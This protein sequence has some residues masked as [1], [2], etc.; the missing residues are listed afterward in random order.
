MWW[1][2]EINDYSETY[3]P[4]FFEIKKNLGISGHISM[5][6]E[7]ILG[8]MPLFGD[9]LAMLLS[10]INWLV[11]F[12]DLAWFFPLAVS[13]T[14]IVGALGMSLFLKKIGVKNRIAMLFGILYMLMPLSIAH[15]KAGHLNIYE[16]VGWYPW[17]L[18]FAYK[19]FSERKIATV[20]YASIFST[21][22]LFSH[23]GMTYILMIFL[24]PIF[25]SSYKKFGWKHILFFFL[26]FLGL[27]AIYLLPSLELHQFINR[28]SITGEDVVPIWTV[29]AFMGGFFFPYAKISSLDQ[30]AV[31]Y[32]GLGILLL[33][34]WQIYRSSKKVKI[35]SIVLI[36]FVTVLTLG[37]QTPLYG[38]LISLL[39]FE[40][41][42]RVSSR[43]WY[44]V[45]LLLI[46]FA[47]RAAGQMKQKNWKAFLI[48]IIIFEYSIFGLLRLNLPGRYG[49][50]KNNLSYFNTNFNTPATFRIYSVNHAISQKKSIEN[51]LLLADG[52]YPLQLK[53]NID[54]LQQAGGYT[55]SRYSVIQPPYQTYALNPQ[56]KAKLLGMMN[57]LYVVSPYKLIDPNFEEILHDKTEITYKNKEFKS[58]LWS[59]N[60][61]LRLNTY[62]PTGDNI[63]ASFH[64]SQDASIYLGLRNYPG[65]NIFLD[66][67]PVSWETDQIWK[68][69]LVPSGSHSLEAR[70][71]N[72]M[73]RWG[74]TITTFTFFIIMFLLIF[75]RFFLK[76]RKL[77]FRKKIP[78]VK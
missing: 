22:A 56:P 61:S 53:A 37:N 42:F 14:F 32:P 28:S 45:L 3:Y 46:I 11:F 5:W 35:I 75:D 59:D 2:T 30:E 7:G 27:G 29:K 68:K 36:L 39:P 13:A 72:T 43:F 49:Y 26:F 50:I 15:I 21:L 52:E 9:P 8:G 33:S 24:I 19:W 73:F 6:R 74:K 18:Y 55:Y 41:V 10:P 66:G 51:N 44:I 77:K 64:V 4:I 17:I 25:F 12:F 16:A 40:G 54:F 69:I 34:L 23:P 48:L 47:A 76:N 63:S 57:V 31:L 38:W 60:K 70:F 20:L 67:R 58:M 62:T 71:D 65:W 1:L 78:F